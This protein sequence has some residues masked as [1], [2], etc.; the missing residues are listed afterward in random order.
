MTVSCLRRLFVASCVLLTQVAAAE[1]MRGPSIAATDPIAVRGGVLMVPL[2]AERAGT[3]WPRVL[4][5][6]ADDGARIQ[7]VVAWVY[8][9]LPDR[10]P[11][12]TADP[13]GL[14]VRA[15]QPDDDTAAGDGA[16]YLIAW[17][18]TDG[19]GTLRVGGQRIEPRWMDPVSWSAPA[20]PP[21]GQGRSAVRPDPQSPFEYWRWVQYAGRMDMKPPPKH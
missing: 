4:E 12:W 8:A 20:L 13:R 3:G 11:A 18:P 15:I 9:R 17:L 7:G 16:P 1:P 14:A 10:D 21:L 2:L 5:L 6:R 19:D